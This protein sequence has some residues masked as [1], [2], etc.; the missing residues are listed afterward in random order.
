MQ[1][2]AYITRGG[3]QKSTPKNMTCDKD[4]IIYHFNKLVNLD[5]MFDCLRIYV[6]KVAQK[7]K[8]H[9]LINNQLKI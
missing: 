3:K 9:K 6:I 8:L 2:W 4:N 7:Y 1:K 5:K